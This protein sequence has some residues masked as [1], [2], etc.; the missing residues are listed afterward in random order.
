M[1]VAAL[2]IILLLLPA[3]HALKINEVL[4]NPAGY[5]DAQMPSGEWVELY[6][7]EDR[8]ISV[9]GFYLY[10]ASDY[11]LPINLDNTQDSTLTIEPGEHLI[12]YRNQNP[13]FTLNNHGDT[14]RLLDGHLSSNPE[15]ID[16][17]TYTTTQEGQSIARTPEFESTEE[18]PSP[19]PINITCPACE[20]PIC[21]P[22]V[23]IVYEK[24]YENKSCPEPTVNKTLV[25][26]SPK[27]QNLNNAKNL[28]IAFLVFIVLVLLK[29]TKK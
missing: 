6:N 9:E 19:E 15:Q 24:V 7:E 4:P 8:A 18:Q 3:T 12:I 22:I 29:P 25:L 11:Y 2:A 20:C 1:R 14:I 21:E 23:E 28:F 27:K 16:V 13:Y 26:S 17:F 5:D 10:D